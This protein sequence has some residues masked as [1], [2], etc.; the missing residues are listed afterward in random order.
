MVGQGRGG[1]RGWSACWERTET[2]KPGPGQIMEGLRA[3]YDMW[4]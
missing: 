3:Y 1:S 4:A 2:T